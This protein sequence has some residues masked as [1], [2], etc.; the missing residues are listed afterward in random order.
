MPLSPA[1]QREQYRARKDTGKC[2]RC[3]TSL[4]DGHS[5][6]CCDDCRAYGADAYE[7]RVQASLCGRC[8]ADVDD[9]RY[10]T[11]GKCRKEARKRVRA[12]ERRLLAEGKCRHCGRQPTRGK[13]SCARCRKQRAMWATEN[14]HL[15]KMRENDGASSTT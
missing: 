6:I 4:P 10:L 1:R 3:G 12:R 9:P 8:S 13:T 11:C 5:F 15:R 14:Y 2:G 7:T